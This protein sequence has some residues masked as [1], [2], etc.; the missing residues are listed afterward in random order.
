MFN[1]LKDVVG[2]G[3]KKNEVE[4]ATR[5]FNY[6]GKSF[7]ASDYTWAR[8]TMQK[9]ARSVMEETDISVSSITDRAIFCIV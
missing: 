8:Y 2:R 9:I 5:L 6:L 1:E 3:F 7:R 4:T